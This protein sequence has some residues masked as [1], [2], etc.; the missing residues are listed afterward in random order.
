MLPKDEIDISEL[1][2]IMPQSTTLLI[3]FPPLDTM[4]LKFSHLLFPVQVLI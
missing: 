3:P 4:T 2:V 1:L